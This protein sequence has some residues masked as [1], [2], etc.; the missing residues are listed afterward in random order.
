MKK[1][2]ECRLKQDNPS[3]EVNQ[4]YVSGSKNCEVDSTCLDLDTN[5]H[6]SG[7]SPG[8]KVKNWRECQQR[9]QKHTNCSFWTN[10]EKEC[11]LKSN[12][13]REEKFGAIS[14]AKNCSGQLSSL[15]KSTSDVAYENEIQIGIIVTLTN[16]S[17]LKNG[18]EFTIIVD[19]N[20]E[21]NKLWSGA[22]TLVSVAPEIVL[23]PK[24]AA[25]LKATKIS[26]SEYTYNLKISHKELSETSATNINIVY[27][28][29]PYLKYV[30][31]STKLAAVSRQKLLS[32]NVDIRSRSF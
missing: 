19:I 17:H 10:S 3:T 23:I 13:R 28:L 24:L 26:S 2:R 14:G 9:C 18:T 27:Q 8:V 29:Q 11:I 15:S 32:N 21:M 22:V 12:N 25:T 30:R 7:I 31:G 16:S 6:K 5:Y 4:F 1:H 20:S